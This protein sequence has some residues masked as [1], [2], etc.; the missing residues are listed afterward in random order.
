MEISEHGG[1]YPSPGPHHGKMLMIIPTVI[2][3]HERLSGTVILP[4][5]L[6]AALPAQ[7]SWISVFPKGPQLRSSINTCPNICGLTLS[8]WAKRGGGLI[9]SRRNAAGFI[10]LLTSLDS[11]REFFSNLPY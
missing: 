6:S 3:A 5:H 11:L 8:Q 7:L 2:L 4:D 10:Q 1:G 9:D